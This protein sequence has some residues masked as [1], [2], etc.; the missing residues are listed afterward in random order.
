[1]QF[2]KKHADSIYPACTATMAVLVIVANIGASKA[3]V[4]GPVLTDG[5]FFIFPL[6][7][8]IT[9]IVTELFS[10]RKAMNMLF[11][12]IIL[13]SL[14]SLLFFIIVLLPGSVSAAQHQ[15]A[16]ETTLLPAAGI[17]FASLLSF[18]VS[19]ATDAFVMSFMKR[20]FSGRHILFRIMG[21]GGIGQL[22][23]TIIFC[24]IAAPLIGITNFDDFL[25]YTGFGFFYKLCMQYLLS[26]LGALVI[27]LLKR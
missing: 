8:L 19:Q 3:V 13:S 17:V 15:I 9:D 16:M 25:I 27:V 2:Y 5:G 24:S 14:S 4:F 21:S 6:V 12:S 22:P 18:L 20:R 10:F 23:D 7:Y 11:I 1:M 26:P